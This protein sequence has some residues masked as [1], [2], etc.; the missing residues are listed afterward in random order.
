MTNKASFSKSIILFLLPILIMAACT[1]AVPT[2]STATPAV[3]ETPTQTPPPS[4]T[5]LPSPTSVAW[6]TQPITAENAGQVAQVNQWGRGRVERTQLIH[7]G[8]GQ[9][10]LTPNG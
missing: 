7:A 10:T 6:T 2:A 5:P 8:Q 4:P 1:P 3:P 9:V